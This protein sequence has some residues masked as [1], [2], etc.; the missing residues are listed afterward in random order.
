MRDIIFRAKTKQGEWVYGLLDSSYFRPNEKYYYIHNCET[1]NIEHEVIP[2]TVGQFTGFT[3]LNG[4]KV[5]EGDIVKDVSC[6]LTHLIY[7]EQGMETLQQAEKNK[8]WGNIGVVKFCLEEVG[9]CGCCYQSFVGSG[10]KANEI[11]ISKCE[12]IGNIHDNP[13]LLEVQDE[14]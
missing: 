4:K 3:D 13:E 7:V 12:V 10:F 9:S 8:K 11:D 1:D 6:Y 5:F 14:R 2:E